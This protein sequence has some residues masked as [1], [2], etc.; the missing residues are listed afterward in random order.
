MDSSSSSDTPTEPSDRTLHRKFKRGV[1]ALFTDR[2]KSSSDVTAPE[3]EKVAEKTQ[4]VA[5]AVAA[6]IKGRIDVPEP[7][8]VPEEEVAEHPAPFNSDIVRI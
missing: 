1:G 4:A 6:D 8:V 5:D 7:V 3:K 2:G